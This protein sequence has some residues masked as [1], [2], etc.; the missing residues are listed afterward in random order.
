VGTW[1]NIK[2]VARSLR[3]TLKRGRRNRES[4]LNPKEIPF[5]MPAEKRLGRVRMRDRF[6]KG[7]RMRSIYR[8][9][10]GRRPL[11]RHAGRNEARKA[12]NRVRDKIAKQ[13][14]KVNR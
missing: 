1:Q 3:D 7:W 14:R 9:K 6:F 10:F 5:S 2:H 11:M 8:A 4:A 13:A 12:R